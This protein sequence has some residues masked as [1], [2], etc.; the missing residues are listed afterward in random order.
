MIP[1]RR[2]TRLPIP[3]ARALGAMYARE[4]RRRNR[5]YDL[6]RA[7]EK[8]R[9]PVISVGNLSAGGTGK[10]PLVQQIVRTLAAQG[11]SPAIAMRGYKSRGSRRSDEELEHA[12]AL[13]G[14]PIIADPDRVR[15]VRGFLETPAGARVDRIVL[16]DG[17]QHRRLARDLDIVVI[18]ATRPPTRDALLPLGFLREPIA[19]LARA[20][21]VVL[22]HAGHAGEEAIETLRAVVSAHLRPGVTISLCAHTWQSLEVHAAGST[23]DEP[24]DWLEARRVGIVC[25]IGNPGAFLRAIEDAG[26]T[27]VAR[28]VLADHAPIAS[29]LIDRIARSGGGSGAAPVVMTPKDFARIHASGARVDEGVRLVVPRLALRFLEGR[30]ELDAL[31]LAAGSDRA[32]PG[33]ARGLE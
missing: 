23:R 5:S 3:I 25:G 13:P 31:C 12:R 9:V 32:P 18:D 26:A 16:D 6:G 27:I 19:S 11:R 21:H 28:E 14:T 20:D 1:E 7:V 22:T 10:T 2:P 17:F 8:V 15:A 4:I 24:V 29:G 30:D 33:H